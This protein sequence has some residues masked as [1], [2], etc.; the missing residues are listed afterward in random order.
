MEIFVKAATLTIAFIV[1]FG[2]LSML[3][4]FPVMWLWN[5]IIPGLLG[6]GTLTWGK[7]WGLMVLCGFLFKSTNTSS[8]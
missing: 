4:A 1:M 6:L 7:A 3:F 5:W 2:L 8:N